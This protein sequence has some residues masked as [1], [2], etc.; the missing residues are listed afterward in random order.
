MFNRD[1]KERIETLERELAAVKNQ[2]A[3]LKQNFGHLTGEN[4]ALRQQNDELK[5]F[6]IVPGKQIRRHE[7]PDYTQSVEPRQDGL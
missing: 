4:H 6:G 3:E 1:L 5:S 7:Y 2:I